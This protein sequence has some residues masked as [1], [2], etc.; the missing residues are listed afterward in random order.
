MSPEIRDDEP[1]LPTGRQ[2]LAR[3][4]A[5]EPGVIGF[6]DR[7]QGNRIS[8]WALDRIDPKAPVE[9]AILVDG[10][11]AARARA[12][13]FRRDLERG[14]F[15]NGHHAFEATLESV[16]EEG[17]AHRV[18]AFAE[19]VDGARVALVNR[20][21]GQPRPT[22]PGPRPASEGDQVLLEIRALRDR[23]EGLAAASPE[24]PPVAIGGA[25]DFL[26]TLV[27]LENLLPSV[28]ARLDA[29]DVVQARLEAA[30]SRLEDR[31][32]PEAGGIRP[33]RGLRIVVSLLGVLSVVSLLLGLRSLL[34]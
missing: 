34:S 16:I 29:F 18:E 21:A 3:R 4:T 15:S 7:V 6:I 31:L 23:I 13:R 28:V 33:E 25:G 14:G 11:E 17:Q 20:P 27:E 1:T 2:S 9:V 12:D 24:G 22:P 32:S 30:I 5:A 19:C 8:G 10:R 26:E